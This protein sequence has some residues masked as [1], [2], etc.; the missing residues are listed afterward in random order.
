MHAA[1]ITLAFMAATRPDSGTSAE[2][3]QFDA[4]DVVE[5]H[6]SPGDRFLIHYTREGPNAVPAADDDG[7]GVPDHVE[8]IGAVYDEVLAFYT[9]ALSYREPLSDAEIDD[10]GGDGRF[11]VY[12]VDFAGAADGAFRQDACAQLACAGF[13]VQE[14]DFAGYDYPSKDYA[15]RL[16]ASHELFHAVQA[17]YDVG[18]GS[19]LGEGTAVWASERFDPDQDDL[20][21][22]ADGYLSTTERTLDRAGTGPVDGFSYGAGIFFEFLSERF[23]DEVV[24]ELWAAAAGESRWLLALD[25]LL[26]Q[27]HGSSFAE[28]FAEFST[29]NLMTGARADP[30][31]SYARGHDY[32]PVAQVQATGPLVDE[33][34]RVFAASS[35]AFDVDPAGR[36]QMTAALVSREPDDD[37]AGLRL[38]LAP[39]RDGAVE[40]LVSVDPA[41]GATPPLLDTAGA[42]SLLVLVVNTRLEGDSARPG[43]CVGDATEVG[44]CAQD[45]VGDTAAPPIAPPPPPQ[46][47][48]G[49][50]ADAAPLSAIA[51]LLASLLACGGRR[52]RGRPARS[53]VD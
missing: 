42:S 43:L 11:D 32:P 38:I 30:A 37:L 4:S 53:A 39:V 1:I 5:S 22:F 50:A 34:L 49:Q 51:V 6:A 8:H 14:N 21:L 17:A 44:A 18:Q 41:A 36:A 2:L 29:W 9:G 7:G 26:A 10:N 27:Q 47:C 19:V 20:E 24:R 35:R 46:G 31:R 33:R 13:M 15:N 23:G 28:A 25:A 12:L 16:L 48:A 3:F 45:L 40:D 52:P